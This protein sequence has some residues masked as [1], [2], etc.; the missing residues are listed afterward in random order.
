MLVGVDTDGGSFMYWKG[1]GVLVCIAG[2]PTL[3]STYAG[4]GSLLRQ[5]KTR[6]LD[7]RNS[8]HTT[9]AISLFGLS[10]T[11][12]LPLAWTFAAKLDY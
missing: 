1:S 7:N 10:Q 11:G 5:Y 12:C 4:E 3:G 9:L 2:R 8:Y 6:P